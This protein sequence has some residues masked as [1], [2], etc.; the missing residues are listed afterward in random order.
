MQMQAHIGLLYFVTEMKDVYFHNFG[1]E[2]V[3]E[4]IKEFVRNKNLKANI[5][6]KQTIQ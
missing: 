4:E 6:F 1:V 5:E 2:H 3:P